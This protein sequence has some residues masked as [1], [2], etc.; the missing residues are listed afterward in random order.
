[1]IGGELAVA[2][3]ALLGFLVEPAS[4]SVELALDGK[5]IGELIV[6][7]WHD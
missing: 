1:V 6:I 2:I 3:V 7:G 5:P 4:P